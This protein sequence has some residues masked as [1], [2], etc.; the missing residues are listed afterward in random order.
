MLQ[1]NQDSNLI[2]FLFRNNL[3]GEIISNQK[4][5]FTRV[6]RIV[7][8]FTIFQAIITL[9]AVFYDV[10]LAWYTAGMTAAAFG[11]MIEPILTF[12]LY[13]G[14]ED[15]A[16]TAKLIAGFISVIIVN[17]ACLAGTALLA[18]ESGE[19][20]NNDWCLALSLGFGV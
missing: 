12:L 16:S 1:M 10:G 18:E 11:V 6:A 3:I 20:F 2:A 8:F 17:G 19:T 13:T 4:A 5:G 9:S 7:I 14:R 15:K